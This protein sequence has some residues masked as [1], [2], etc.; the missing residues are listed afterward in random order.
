VKLSSLREK[1]DS[2]ANELAR[3]MLDSWKAAEMQKSVAREVEL[4]I[5]SI[6]A[7]AKNEIQQAHHQARLDLQTWKTAEGKLLRQDAINRSEATHKGKITE[8]LAALFLNDIFDPR[9]IRF[10]GSPIDL[11]V[12]H[13]LAAGYIEAIHFIEVKS[14]KSAK[15]APR[16]ELVRG[17][18][19]AG[20][21]AYN[22]VHFADDDSD[23]GI[24]VNWLGG[25]PPKLSQIMNEELRILI[26]KKCDACRAI[27][28]DVQADL[29]V[30]IYENFGRSMARL[31]DEV[32]I[33]RDEVKSMKPRD[34]KPRKNS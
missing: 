22:I 19:L 25:P 8:H 32:A 3:S 34:K 18:A 5:S 26:A 28:V 10:I 27:D 24:S 13:G 33:L 20:R 23:I 29:D 14:G 6:R 31:A 1:M 9:D 15:L 2:R 17:A 4:S 21:V 11:I 12:F 16:E 7:Q 30:L